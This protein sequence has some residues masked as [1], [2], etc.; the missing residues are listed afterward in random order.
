MTTAAAPPAVRRIITLNDPHGRGVCLDDGPA[1]D[2]HTDP[3]RPGFS[4]TRVWL[5]DQF[6][7][8]FHQGRDLTREAPLSLQPPPRGSILW[9][10]RLPPDATWQGQVGRAEVEAYFRSVGSPEASRYAAD[11]PHPYMQQTRTLD[12]C[13]VLEGA[14][15]LVLD[16]Q[17]VALQAHDNVVQRGTSH[18]WSNRSDQPCVLA[19]SSH[20]GTFTR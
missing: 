2:V 8:R 5:T 4:L 10:L 9:V 1:P 18:A 12:F 7:A 6:P 14:V 20:D 19:I 16:T 11:A 3:A 17:E 15:T 13:L